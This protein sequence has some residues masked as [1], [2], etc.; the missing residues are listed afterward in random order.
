MRGP[1][2]VFQIVNIL[3]NIFFFCVYALRGVG[4]AIHPQNIDKL[5]PIHFLDIRLNG[6]ARKRSERY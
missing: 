1:V 5:L 2:K 6:M 4:N 3:E